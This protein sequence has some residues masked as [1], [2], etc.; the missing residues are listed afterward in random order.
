VA[1]SPTANI[2]IDDM[3]NRVAEISAAK[4]AATSPILRILHSRTK[5]KRKAIDVVPNSRQRDSTRQV[6]GT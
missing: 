4:E 1:E 3:G 2:V 5:N 6:S